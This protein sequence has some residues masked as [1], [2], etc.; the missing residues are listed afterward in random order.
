LRITIGN[1]LADCLSKSFLVHTRPKIE[2]RRVV[3][4]DA[5]APIPTARRREPPPRFLAIRK[6]PQ[7]PREKK[8]LADSSPRL[9]TPAKVVELTFRAYFPAVLEWEL[10]NVVLPLLPVRAAKTYQ[11][12]H[13]TN[14]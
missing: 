6:D 14:G 11:G 7:V 9:S 1:G 4:A 2:T 3:P 10:R 5:A 13:P 12:D 8:A